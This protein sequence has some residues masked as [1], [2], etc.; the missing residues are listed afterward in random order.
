MMMKTKIIQWFG[1]FLILVI[2][3]IHLYMFPE[4]YEEAHLLG[5][6][7]IANFFTAVIASIGIRRG[8]T[9]GWVLGIIIALGSIYGYVL[10]RSVGM[11][12]M[13]VEAWL[14]PIGLLSLVLEV[15]FVILAF[16]LKPWGKL[17]NN[18]KTVLSSIYLL[19]VVAFGILGY[20]GSI[21]A[22]NSRMAH[23]SDA[24]LISAS[25]LEEQYGVQVRL[26]GVSMMGSIVDFRL[27]V[28]DVEK[29]RKLLDNPDKMPML[30]VDD[31]DT[32]LTAPMP[33][34]H[35]HKVKESSI[36]YLFFPN[37]GN[38]VHPGTPVSVVIGDLRVE[39][40]LAQ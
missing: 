12:G 22:E 14:Y 5:Y 31:S 8:K 6:L 27:Y 1:V 37:K 9:W 26:V 16:T 24:K 32:I 35:Q 25:T 4:E 21:D 30:V 20:L 19:A 38:T 33:H 40:V 3:I 18:H 11:P 36:F 29:A 39:P 15:G 23:I 28:T 7:F 2:G 13:D 34:G 10:S 17:T